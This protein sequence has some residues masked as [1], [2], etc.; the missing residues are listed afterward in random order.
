MIKQ[1]IDGISIALD[2]DFGDTCK[3]YDESIKQGLKEPCF[4]IVCLNPTENLFLGKRYFRQNQFDVLYFS[5][6][7]TNAECFAIAEKLFNT[8]EYITVNGDLQRGTQMHTNVEDGVLHFFVN[9]DLFVYKVED[10]TPMESM[11]YAN[12]VEG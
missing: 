10:K 6:T 9:Y 12:N 8:L 3:I 1:I 7:K 2:E 11:D 5:K 4:S